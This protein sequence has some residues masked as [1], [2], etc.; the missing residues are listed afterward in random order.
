MC[1]CVCVGGAGRDR[2]IR[3][4]RKVSGVNNEPI[5]TAQTG[6]KML[7]VPCGW[8]YGEKREDGAVKQDYE[9]RRQS[10]LF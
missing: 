10:N 6:G 5:P 9:V 1:V 4:P 7:P 2:A 8:D 3:A